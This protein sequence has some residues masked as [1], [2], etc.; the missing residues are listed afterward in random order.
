MPRRLFKQLS[1]QR[2]HLRTR[3]YMK[4]FQSVFGESSYWSLNRRNVTRAVALGLF[5][6]F[7]PPPIPHTLMA[8][9]AAIALRVNIPVTLTSIFITNPVTMGPLY[10]AA[11]WVGCHVLGDTPMTRLPKAAPGDWL[12]A[13]HGP[14][15]EPFIIGC[16]LLGLAVAVLGYIVLGLSWHLSLVYKFYQRKRLRREKEN[17][18][19][20]P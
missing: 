19:N 18:R 5:I 17:R 13:F 9:F 7:L 2:H 8:V 11:Y 15:L 1:R 10:Y 14:I 16:L 6:A 4:P 3:W 12:P 20:S